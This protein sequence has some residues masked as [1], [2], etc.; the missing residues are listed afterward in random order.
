MGV[1]YTAFMMAA[2][3]SIIYPRLKQRRMRTAEEKRT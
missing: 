1:Y 3:V 2:F